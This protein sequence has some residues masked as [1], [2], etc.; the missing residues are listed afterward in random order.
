METLT[1]DIISG[2]PCKITFAEFNDNINKLPRRQDFTDPDLRRVFSNKVAQKQPLLFMPN[3]VSAN[4]FGP[5]E[6][7]V[8][9]ILPDGSKTCVKLRDIPIHVDVCSNGMSIEELKLL[10][11][12]EANKCSYDD[13]LSF[14]EPIIVEQYLLHGFQ[15]APTMWLRYNFKEFPHR[16]KFVKFL[17]QLKNQK[18]MSG[19]LT[20]NL[21]TAND[22]SMARGEQYYMVAAA[23]HLFN[24]GG[25]NRITD[26]DVVTDARNTTRADYTISVSIKNYLALD[27]AKLEEIKSNRTSTIATK[28]A[29]AM[30]RDPTM[31]LQWDIET[32]KE[33]DDGRAPE[34]G[35][36]DFTIFNMCSGFFW[37]YSPKPLYTVSVIIGDSDADDPDVSLVVVC[38]NER[39]LLIANYTLWSRMMPDAMDAFNGAGFDWPIYREKLRRANLIPEFIDSMSLVPDNRIINYLKQTFKTDKDRREA[40]A[41]ITQNAL[42][43]SWSSSEKIKIDAENNHLLGAV[44]NTAGIIDLDMLP[45][46]L[47]L[48]P[49]AEVPKL[50]SLNFF[51]SKNKL[52]AKE[53]MPYKLMFKIFERSRDLQ[54]IDGT[55]K[56]KLRPCLDCVPIGGSS[57]ADAT[58]T[59]CIRPE[60][61]IDPNGFNKIELPP[62]P[63][64]IL[65]LAKVEITPSAELLANLRPIEAFRK[66]SSRDMAL[67]GKYCVIDCVRPQQLMVKRVIYTEHRE[68][69][70]LSRTGIYEAFYRAGGMK[71][72]NLV[73]INAIHK[74]NIGFPNGRA[75]KKQEEKNHFPG[76]WVF[77]PKRAMHTDRPI[78]GEDVASLYPSLMMTY[79]LSPDMVVK[80]PKVAEQLQSDGYTLHHIGP[81]NYEQGKEKGEAIN[82]H[83]VAEGWVV[84]H[85]GAYGTDSGYTHT[86]KKNAKNVEIDVV[87]EETKVKSKKT[88]RKVTYDMHRDRLILEGEKMGI[89]PY[90]VKD[91]FDM[92][93][94]I[95]KEFVRLSE[96]IENMHLTHQT[97]Y[98]DNGVTYTLD[99]M[100]FR[101]MCIEAKQK[102]IKL[103]SNTIYGKAG[104]YL[105]SIYELL[106][107]GGV[108]TAGQATIK[109]ADKF[110]KSLG[111]ETCYGDTDSLYLKCP[112]EIYAECDLVYKNECEFGSTIVDAIAKYKYLLKAKLRYWTVMVE[113][114]MKQMA[115]L[116]EQL[117]DHMLEFN[118]TNF[119]NLAYEEVLFPTGLLGKKKYFGTP[120]LKKVNF[121]F[122]EAS[123]DLIIDDLVA[124]GKFN[125]LELNKIMTTV[126]LELFIRGIEVIKQGK[127]EVAKSIGTDV[128]KRA[129]SV[130]NNKSMMEIV[131]S[132][133][134]DFYVTDHKP[135]DFS[136]LGRY[137]PDKVNVPM[138]TF[139]KRMQQA[140]SDGLD[141]SLYT[142]SEPGD[143]FRYV[144]CKKA[145]RWTLSGKKIEIKKGD[146]MEFMRV[147]DASQDPTKNVEPIEIDKNYYMKNSIVGILAR[148][149]SYYEQFLPEEGKFDPADE[150]YYKKFDEYCVHEASKYLEAICDTITGIDKK[151]NFRTGVDYRAIY[152]SVRK[153]VNCLLAD[154][155]GVN[156]A[157]IVGTFDANENISDVI[158]THVSD[159]DRT[160]KYT[161]FN[162]I[163]AST[164]MEYDKLYKMRIEQFK[165]DEKNKLDDVYQKYIIVKPI[166][167]RYTEALT[168]FVESC[169]ML[170]R[171]VDLDGLEFNFMISNEEI[172]YINEFMRA[173]NAMSNMYELRACAKATQS[174]LLAERKK[175]IQ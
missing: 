131:E 148:F 4:R 113:L 79:N 63:R 20:H 149:I 102:A 166:L 6:L 89:F 2:K 163:T 57:M 159:I 44:F 119:I 90:T 93:V 126:K 10:I 46:M 34:P 8:Y 48:Y 18:N 5:F 141:P 173:W 147:Y 94:P 53:D 145:L 68:L 98:I 144:I 114:T 100:E 58:Y 76:A 138:H 65:G 36:V 32:H 26:Y 1:Q 24:T 85:N 45:L 111:Y 56:I 47:K 135:V 55:D 30:T 128:M 106:V 88:I 64:D 67:V 91:L 70:N 105:C 35:D 121:G 123:I 120:H 73:R 75:H 60:L 7:H 25:W 50:A 109:S 151:E 69:A 41:Q 171:E 136:L 164:I 11:K 97:E 77:P 169:R 28:L 125:E 92:R 103:L 86:Y 71:V 39:E 175:M 81:F 52:Q 117:S 31:V 74:F 101:C 21:H 162:K 157:F 62:G 150:K 133:V 27:N 152:K 78:T 104:D 59:D 14:E 172:E 3:A 87:D 118:G 155:Y 49:R 127:A 167:S 139:Y 170:G 108:T 13:R 22:D 17:D 142:P 16:V 33:I 15:K 154:E 9:G 66:Q 165:R 129:V 122:T 112:P 143:K 137:K 43:W 158:K 130:L 12:I 174:H 107:A 84:R 29:D 82:T 51:L 54:S 146:Q 37:Q 80:D 99:D 38:K 42:K 40:S 168:R 140:I 161:T 132:M 19:E 72:I 156:V 116:S 134:R 124:N 61:L 23:R 153:H 96:I 95:K 110:C 115:Q 83:L 160:A